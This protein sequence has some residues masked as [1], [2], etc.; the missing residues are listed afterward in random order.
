MKRDRHS[1]IQWGRV[2]RRSAA[3]FMVTVALWALLTAAGAGAAAEAFRALGED[4]SLV[5]ALLRAE[6]GEVEGT[7]GPFDALNGLGRLVVGQSALLRSNEDAVAQWLSGALDGEDGAEQQPSPAPS[8]DPSPAPEG[9]DPEDPANLPAVTTAPDDIIPRTLVPSSGSGYAQ[10]DGVYIYNA[11]GLEVDAAA[12]AAAP[13]NITL[14]DTEEPQILIMHT[15]ATEAYT[16][17]GTDLYVQTDNSRTLDNTQNMVRIGEEMKAVF[18]EMGLSV[19]HDETPYDYPQ[20]NGA[21]GRSGAGVEEYLAQY[22]SIKIVLDVH[23]DALIGEDGT[24]YKPLTTVD[25]QDTAQVMLVMGSPEA[26]DY[27]RWM[28]NLTLAMKIQKS[29]NALYPT[30][31]RP[32]TMRSSSVYNQ[33]L[34]NGSLLVEVG[35]HGN[36]LQEAIRGAR[37][38]ARAAGQVLLGLEEDGG[39]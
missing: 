17:D 11:T 32:I 1:G 24:V 21:Y 38:F 12:L 22:P 26:G 6:L 16:P 20:Y 10:A 13:V 31:A 9:E 23:R 29:M 34:T 3:L 8:A 19:I 28:E 15:H 35:A 7:G 33:A 39:T 14:A 25:G 5:S 37:L 36:T 4:G 30:L 27:P 2:L 18:E